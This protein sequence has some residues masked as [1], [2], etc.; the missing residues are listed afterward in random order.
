MKQKI[1]VFIAMI[2]P[3]EYRVE[4]KSLDEYR[5]CMKR[6]DKDWNEF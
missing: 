5:K 1:E 4:M 3:Y 2:N 6:V